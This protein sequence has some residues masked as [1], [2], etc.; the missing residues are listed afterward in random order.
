[1]N[2]KKITTTLFLVAS[3][4]LL[5]SQSSEMGSKPTQIDRK[6]SISTTYYSFMNFEKE[7]TNTHHYELHFGYQITPK[8]KIGIKFATWNRLS[9]I[10][11]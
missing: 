2:Y 4:G 9:F 11:L 5:F 1:M 10:F 8:D 3:F 6:F 7:K